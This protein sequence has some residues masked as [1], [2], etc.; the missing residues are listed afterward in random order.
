MVSVLRRRATDSLRSIRH[1]TARTA[2]AC[3]RGAFDLLPSRHRKDP[4]CTP[5]HGV[6]TT[7]AA[8]SIG[9][10]T[11]GD[12][13]GAATTTAAAGMRPRFTLSDDVSP[14]PSTQSSPRTWA[15]MFT[16]RHGV[17]R[18]PNGLIALSDR[19]TIPTT[20]SWSNQRIKGYP[21]EDF[22]RHAVAAAAAA[23]FGPGP[24][25][26]VDFRA[27]SLPPPPTIAATANTT[28]AARQTVAATAANSPGETTG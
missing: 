10:F 16:G 8:V 11:E 5:A 9:T 28:A 20:G 6:A 25:G 14:C 19:T 15:G 27:L 7:L 13:G 4:L 2:A 3:R 12:G 18:V 17:L 23:G 22:N 21:V 1:R 26:H 24:E